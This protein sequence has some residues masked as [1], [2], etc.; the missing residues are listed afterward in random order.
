MNQVTVCLRGRTSFVRTLLRG[1]SRP[2]GLLDPILN[3]SMWKRSQTGPEG[4][5]QSLPRTDIWIYPSCLTIDDR[6]ETG[7]ASCL[8]KFKWARTQ[9][10]FQM[11][12]ITSKLLDLETSTGLTELVFSSPIWYFL[13]LGERRKMG[14]V[15]SLPPTTRLERDGRV[16]NPRFPVWRP[17]SRFTSGVK[18]STWLPRFISFACV[19]YMQLRRGFLFRRKLGLVVFWILCWWSVLFWCLSNGE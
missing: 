13:S 14:R 3:E 18:P 12:E 8:G 5:I 16:T 9:A 6:C 1:V 11:A 2:K 17:D 19:F 15:R 7:Q 4:F 10:R